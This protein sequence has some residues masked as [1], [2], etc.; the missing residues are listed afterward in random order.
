[1]KKAIRLTYLLNKRLY[2]KVTFC[3]ILLF[4]PL[5]VMALNFTA[6]QD[7][8]FVTIALAQK[9]PKDVVAGQIID[10]ISKDSGLILFVRCDETQALKKVKTGQVDAAWIFPENTAEKLDT[11]AEVRDQDNYIVNVVEGEESIALK[12]SREKLSAALIKHMSDSVYINYIRDNLPQLDSISDDE[13]YSYY[14]NYNS[15]TELFEFVGVDGKAKGDESLNYLTA[16]IRG[17]LSVLVVLGALAAALFYADDAQDGTFV[18]HSPKFRPLIPFLQQLVAVGN[19]AVF[20]LAALFISG[21]NV[22]VIRE[23]GVLLLYIIACS[24]F[25]ILILQMF[26]S[27]KTISVIT[28]LLITVMIA[29]CPVFFSFKATRPLQM[30][31]PPTYYINAISNNRSVMYMVVYIICL[32]VLCM[33]LYLFDRKKMHDR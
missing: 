10:E 15:E 32:L 31:F 11:F 4:I 9:N 23:V 22:S 5:A 7:S 17:L 29:I 14:N 25:G 20:M 27:K 8:G 18:L 28:P 16:P 33:A 13:L 24:L 30:L 12:L 3:I 26:R 6:R 21:L 19:V 1:M 2:K